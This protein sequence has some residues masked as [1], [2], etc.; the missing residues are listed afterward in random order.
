MKIRL[1]F[2]SLCC[3]VT[4]LMLFVVSVSA[5]Q[6]AAD[7]RRQIEE[8]R[9]QQ[10]EIQAE[11]DE[12][13][14]QLEET[15]QEKNDTEIA[16]AEIDEDLTKATNDFLSVIDRI[17]RTIEALNQKELE[18]IEAKE[19][20]DEQQEVFRQRL[21]FMHKN[22]AISYLDIIFEAKSFTDFVNRVEYINR[23]ARHD[24]TL[25]NRLSD[26]ERL[27]AETFDEIDRQQTTF[28]R[29]AAEREI[30]QLEL[31]ETMDRKQEL[32]YQLVSDEQAFEEMLDMLEETENEIVE[33]IQQ[34][35]LEAAEAA[36]AEA[37][38]IWGAGGGNGFAASASI[39][40]GAF[41]GRMQWPVPGRYVLSDTFRSRN[42][43]VHG[44]WEF[45]S[46]IDIPAP[47][48]TA[49]V[50]AE[51]GV[52]LSA[53]W[54]SGYGNTVIIDHG[55]GISTL[56]AHNSQLTVRSSQTVERGELIARAGSTGNSTGPHLHFEVRI[57]G[58]PVNP[59]AF[60]N[61]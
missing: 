50:A 37:A 59:N 29:L 23:I 38:A 44:R 42:N 19:R 30:R 52:V 40:S 1:A 58:N 17:E 51:R 10:E 46:G 56:Y 25:L 14:Q 16:M 15:M 57:N 35:E 4:A 5:G 31:Q 36:A 41:S 61:F 54:I 43:P 33:L 21:N 13:K 28:E 45:H 3:I 2:A 11:Q 22:G 32:F 55:N 48:G 20:R 7:I 8:L 27:I 60:L 26:T 6:T 49:I 9:E 34:R 47:T 12:A 24:K 18:L 53:G 39:N